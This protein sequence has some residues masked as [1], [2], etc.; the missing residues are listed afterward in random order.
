MDSEVKPSVANDRRPEDLK[1]RRS[2]MTSDWSW[3]LP[4]TVDQSHGSS[5]LETLPRAGNVSSDTRAG[6]AA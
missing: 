2:A 4:S 3:T 6:T 1:I 5:N